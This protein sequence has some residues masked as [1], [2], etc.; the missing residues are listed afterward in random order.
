MLY[1]F[2]FFCFLNE[3][4]VPS[5]HWSFDNKNSYFYLHIQDNKGFIITFILCS[6]EKNLF[7]LLLFGFEFISIDFINHF[8]VFMDIKIIICGKL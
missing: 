6:L 7:F 4:N 3:I 1:F 5:S 2:S 8:I